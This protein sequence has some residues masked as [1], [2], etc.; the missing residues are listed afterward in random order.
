MGDHWIQLALVAVLIIMNALFSGSEMALV[1]LREGQLR[2][3]E[4]LGGGA[5]AIRGAES[6]GAKLDL[7]FGGQGAPLSR[8]YRRSSV[9]FNRRSESRKASSPTA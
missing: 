6:G 1:S 7:G 9:L 4:Q 5:A 3:M 8:S 2:R